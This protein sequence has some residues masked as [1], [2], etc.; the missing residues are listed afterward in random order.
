MGARS[1]PVSHPL[2]GSLKRWPSVS[3]PLGPVRRVGRSNGD[4]CT[5]QLASG[6]FLELGTP[7]SKVRVRD[8]EGVPRADQKALLDTQPLSRLVNRQ[9]RDLHVGTNRSS[10]IGYRTRTEPVDHSVLYWFVAPPAVAVES[11]R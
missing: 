8:R 6:R 11:R 2:S 10:R 9:I 7:L 3:S 1:C 5:H 4:G